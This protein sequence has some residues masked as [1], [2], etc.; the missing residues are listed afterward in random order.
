M[1]D[2]E[3]AILDPQRV[4]AIFQDS[5][6][7]EGEDATAHIKTDG[8]INNITFNP[9]RLE[10]HR[11]EVRLMLNE[12]PDEF[13]ASKGGGMTFLNAC[14]DKHGNLWTGSQ[15]AMAKLFE[16]GI[17]L[18]IAKFSFPREFWSALPGGMPYYVISA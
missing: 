15:A 16:L 11:E 5:L 7:K 12:L 10:S 3:A 8:L 2:R 9:E 1:S 13:M 17:A 6:T 18:G 14:N 4:D